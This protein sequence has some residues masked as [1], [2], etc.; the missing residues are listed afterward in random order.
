MF[1]GYKD[2]KSNQ[3]VSFMTSF[4]IFGKIENMANCQWIAL[5]ENNA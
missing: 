1:S 3:I 2:E 4:F 5:T